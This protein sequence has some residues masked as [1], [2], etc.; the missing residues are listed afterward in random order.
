MPY[1]TRRIWNP[2]LYQGG[3]V[4][5]RYFEGWY[6]KQADASQENVFA[7]IPGVA[8]SADGAAS[9]A[10]IQLVPGGG[11]AHYFA[12]P[13]DAFSF[14]RTEPFEL[15]IAGNT[16]SRSGI[17]VNLAEAGRTVSGSIGFGPW[18]PWPVRALSPGIMGWYRFV[19]RMET[20]HGVLSMD[21]ALSGSLTIDGRH[22]DLDGGRGYVEKD[23]GHSFPSSWIW[24]QSNHF[25]RP[26]VSVSVSVAKVPWMGSSFVGN[27]AGLLFDG[28]LHRF[29]TYT[30]A[31]P[32]CVETGD[33]EARIVLADRREEI[34]IEL[35]G[36]ETMVL[37]APVLGA[38]EGR[39]AES[40]GGTMHVTLRSKRGGRAG[41]VF[42]G[43]GRLAGIEVMNDKNELQFATATTSRT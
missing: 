26:G 23:W 22:I 18:W 5:R 11:D 39:D 42:E 24:A 16:F 1:A 34:E 30:G 2:A 13:I 33:G 7:I 27:I 8:Y 37:A 40:L 10:F 14:S 20:Y 6:F 17:T 9:H 41:V 12:F 28:E 21:H 43:T 15:S 25:G 32:V 38:M 35:Y 4:K 19:P 3:A 29:T 36:S 31:K